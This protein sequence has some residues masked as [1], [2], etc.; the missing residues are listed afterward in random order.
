[1]CFVCTNS[2]YKLIKDQKHDHW[3]ERMNAVYKSGFA[4]L[5]NDRE[6]MD[7]GRIS[8]RAVDSWIPDSAFKAFYTTNSWKR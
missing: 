7:G 6:Q 2:C 1:M 4:F 3:E 8:A 5:E